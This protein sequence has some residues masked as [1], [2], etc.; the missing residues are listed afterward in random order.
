MRFFA[1]LILFTISGFAADSTRPSVHVRNFAVVNDHILRGG[2]PTAEGLNELHAAGVNLIL[3]LREPSAATE[4]EKQQAGKLGMD[5]R[6]LPLR[7]FSAPTAAQIKTLLDL[8]DQN[9]S[10]KIFVHCRRGK[11]RTGTVIACYRIQHDGWTN[12]RALEEAHMLGMS[13]LEYGMRSF[14]LHFTPISVVT[15]PALVTH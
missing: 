11:D 12:Q 8:I 3:D 4:F 5:Y 2:E 9:N 7:E 13:S 6:N 1:F 10:Q 14:I 15:D